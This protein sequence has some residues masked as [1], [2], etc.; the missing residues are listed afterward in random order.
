MANNV[1]EIKDLSI[2]YEMREGVVKALNGVD[3]ALK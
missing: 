1:L 3:L 2:H